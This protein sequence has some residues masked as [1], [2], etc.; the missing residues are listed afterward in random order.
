MNSGCVIGVFLTNSPMI[1]LQNG[2]STTLHF[3]TFCFTE[4]THTLLKVKRARNQ[5]QTVPLTAR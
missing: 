5:L 3:S 4:I 1:M 2:I